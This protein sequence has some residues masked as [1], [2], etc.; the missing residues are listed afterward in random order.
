MSKPERNSC[1]LYLY[2]A[3][4]LYILCVTS[5]YGD[6]ETT[7]KDVAYPHDDEVAHLNLEDERALKEVEASLLKLE[8]IVPDTASGGKAVLREMMP[9]S[10]SSSSVSL[11][12][13]GDYTDTNAIIQPDENLDISQTVNDTYFVRLSIRTSHSY[14]AATNDTI[15]AM[16]VGDFSSSG[17]HDVPYKF[18]ETGKHVSFL[19]ELSRQI[20]NLTEIVFYNMGHDGWLPASVACQK[21]QTMYTLAGPRQW[22]DSYSPSLFHSSGD[23]Y[24]PDDQEHLPAASSLFMKVVD[25]FTLYTLNGLQVQ[26]DGTVY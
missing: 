16:F 11:Q 8:N 17:P 26:L 7:E 3:L 4:V 20:G 24:E 5:S 9:P 18:N 22:V 10:S 19:M 23:G 21:D 12:D 1:W 6:S 14:L 13:Q 25:E 15:Q 2:Y